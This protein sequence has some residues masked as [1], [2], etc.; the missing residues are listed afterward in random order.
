MKKDIFI[1]YLKNELE[2]KNAV[3]AANS[4]SDEDK[5]TVQAQIDNLQAILDRVEEIEDEEVSR[6]VVD[7]LVET[8][9]GLAEK[10]QALSE[11]LQLKQDNQ[12][13]NDSNK[14]NQ[15]DNEYLKSTNAVRDFADA[16]RNSRTAD[17]FR[18]NWNAYL[19]QNSIE[20]T[21][22]SEEAFL[23]EAVKG[24]ITDL[25]EKGAGWLADLTNTNA[26]AFWVRHNTSEKDAETSRAK[27][28]KKGDTKVAQQIT[29]A[30]KKL[31]PQFIY[32]L[33]EID[34]Q[35][36]F[37][38]D[39]D[40]INYV[41]GELVDKILYEIRRAILVGDGRANDS[42]FKINSFEAIAKTTT[43][44]YTTVS[45]ASSAFLVD[46]MRAMVDDIVNENSKP[47]YVFMSKADL[48]TLARVQA[49]ETSTPVYLSEEQV[50]EQIGAT[51]IYTT[52]LLGSD[53]K[54]VAMIPS[55]YY[56]VGEGVLNPSLMTAHDIYKNLD[57]Y[58]YECVAGG[59]INALKSTAVLKAE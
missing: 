53:Y 16:I 49:S 12:D 5:A 8:V 24:R 46:D 47:V 58:R 28:W 57:V 23:P 25:W 40:L 1:E 30:A 3:I 26:K 48:R 10:L 44:A 9:N 54:A 21:A 33:Q 50:A 15:M 13:N 43:D 41:L 56:L 7:G 59:G 39:E 52:D 22:G 34:L 2:A 29:L 38:N 17:E 27:G 19:A 20:V 35:T 6:E 4:I 55:E 51:K 31:V 45:T 32:K 36:K 42:D 37:E 14:E 11:K 18:A